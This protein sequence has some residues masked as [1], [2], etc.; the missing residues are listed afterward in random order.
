MSCTD[1]VTLAANHHLASQSSISFRLLWVIRDALSGRLLKTTSG[2]DVSPAKVATIAFG[3]CGIRAVKRVY[4]TGPSAEPCD[5][6][7]DFMKS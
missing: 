7:G 6:C 1:F 4:I 5:T 2:N 3:F